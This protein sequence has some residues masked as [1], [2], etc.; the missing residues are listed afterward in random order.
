MADVLATPAGKSRAGDFL[1]SFLTVAL[2]ALA[3]E[4]AF[5]FSYWLRFNSSLF[6]QLG[7]IDEDAPSLQTY[8][9]SS[10]VVIAIW[11]ML[12]HSRRM[13][14]P[15]RSVTL[16]DEL[17]NIGKVVSLGMLMVMSAAFLYREFSYSRI[18]FGLLWIN[19]IGLIIAGRTGVRWFE[20]HLYRK[21]KHLRQA[22]ILG[23]N[24]SAADV[25][26]RLNGHP[27][28]GFLILGYFSETNASEESPLSRATHLG[29]ISAAGPFIRSHGVDLA[30]IAL[31]P[32]DRAI[33]FDFIGEC[34]GINVEFMM[35]PD[36]LEVLT[37]QVKLTELEG[38]PL[39]KIK[40]I[41]FTLWGRITKRTLDVAVSTVALLLFLPI[42]PL[43]MIMIKLNSPGPV[44]FKQERIGLDGKKFLIYK[45]RSMKVGAEAQQVLVGHGMKNDPR[46]TRVGVLLRKTSLDEIPQLINVLKGEMSLVGPRPET[47]QL[48]NEFRRVIPKYLD[49]H[50]V[51][52]GM[53]G[54][55]QVN[56]LRG[57]TSIEERVKYDLYYIE[58]WSLA[59]DIKILIRTLRAALDLK[60]IY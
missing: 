28:F 41:P 57:D 44:F 40:S 19:S 60:N 11:L 27:S 5:L 43:I 46:R 22:I 12:F 8:I 2:D 29:T 3:I 59:F 37:S 49:R 26:T 51:K 6:D 15:R 4:G 30:F 45:F 47:T 20:R 13:Y 32:E 10:L 14:S 23:N 17:M 24:S 21:G 50:R 36:V 56:G 31:R 34:E 53:T 16:S 48:V 9:L 54:W 55:A 58:N 35:V 33:L 1:I 38:I 39:L 7:Y 25:Y 18:V 52:T 42:F